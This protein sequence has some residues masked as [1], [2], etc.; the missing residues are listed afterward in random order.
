VQSIEENAYEDY[1]EFNEI[2]TKCASCGYD[3]GGV[4]KMNEAEQTES[5][6]K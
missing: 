3:F 2:V 5:T 1:N 4:I 6:E